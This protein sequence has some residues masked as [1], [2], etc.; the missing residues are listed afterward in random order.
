[1]LV[2]VAWPIKQRTEICNKTL[3]YSYSGI[4]SI[5]STLRIYLKEKCLNA[6]KII[7]VRKCLFVR[8]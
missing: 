1:M 6:E 4:R 8:T 7:T 2:I 5:E 3:V